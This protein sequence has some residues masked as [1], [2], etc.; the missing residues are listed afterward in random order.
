MFGA[1]E[2]NRGLPLHPFSEPL[3]EPFPSTHMLVSRSG[4]WN[5][6]FAAVAERARGVTLQKISASLA[7]E[8]VL[9][10][11]KPGDDRSAIVLSLVRGQSG[12]SATRE[13]PKAAQKP[14][15]FVQIARKYLLGRKVLSISASLSPLAF[16][17]RF[18]LPHPEAEDREDLLAGPDHLILDLEDKPPRLILAKRTESV[19]ARYSQVAPAYAQGQP[20]YESFC[21]W[22]TEG[23]KTKRRA[24]FERPL[25][26]Y[27]PLPSAKPAANPEATLVATPDAAL[28]SL[29]KDIC[30]VTAVAAPSAT[31]SPIATHDETPLTL[32]G[33]FTLLPA[34]LRRAA[35]TRHQFL[36]RRLQRQR[37][38]F[39]PDAEIERS[40]KRAEGLRSY[41]YLWP[42]GS[43][44]WHVPPHLIE[45]TGLP[46]VL[47]LESGRK[48]GDL[49]DAAFGLVDKLKRRQSEL[50]TRIRESERA[51]AAFERQVESAALALRNPQ[52]NLVPE[53]VK[54]LA[55]GLDVALAPQSARQL[56]R[57][58][59]RER[60]RPFRSYLASSGEF[61]RV[62]KSALDSDAMLRQMPAHHWWL[63]VLTGEGPHVWLEAPKKQ[64]PASAAIREAAVLAVHHS[65]QGRGM[66]A[67]VRIARRADVE[68]RKDLAPGKVIIRR[69]DTLTI[70]Y[71]RAELEGILAGAK[72]PA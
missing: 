9:Q 19:D 26:G 60:K 51:L 30:A 64:K 8:L 54:L 42:E 68:K 4:V 23:L 59:E 5:A 15:G 72:D 36:A 45:E 44:S 49:C 2:F 16:V 17:L 21:E 43:S 3:P 48:P 20:F 34:P 25:L 70:R 55:Q 33:A 46:A 61:I 58:A 6:R 38:D 31:A 40:M 29:A 10:V 37:Q 69:A 22:S 28:A 13:K 39:P 56:A 18:E 1:T 35:K 24:A 67:D 63:H 65:R 47:N 66:A 27:C 62:A 53:P 14:N 7:G 57:E 11:Y 41:L 71:E 12:P 50:T 32:A 52:D